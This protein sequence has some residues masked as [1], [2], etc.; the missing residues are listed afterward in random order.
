MSIDASIDDDFRDALARGDELAWYTF[1]QR[2]TQRLNRYA[3]AVVNNE[4][5]ARDTV[6]AV[7]VG[8]VRNRKQLDQVR[9]FEAYLFSAVRRDLWRAVKQEQKEAAILVPLDV[10]KNGQVRSLQLADCKHAGTSVEDR[11][12]VSVALSR[13]ATEVRVVI[14]L[15]YFGEL[16]F[17]KIGT[18]LDLPL[19][20]VVSRFRAGLKQLRSSVGDLA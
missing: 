2:Y 16:T 14:E 5:L 20:T 3:R 12:F 9:D 10:E 19:G 11:D 8:L 13:L 4:E 15:R 1:H 6:Q 17:E 7:M 18:V